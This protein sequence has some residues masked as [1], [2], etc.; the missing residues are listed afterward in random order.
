[1]ATAMHD[2]LDLCRREGIPT[3]LVLMP[4]GPLYRS[5]YTPD[6]HAK[7]QAFL[8]DLQQKHKVPLLDA[9]DWIPE[10]DFNDSHHL[11]LHGAE[12]FS[13]RMVHDFLLPILSRL[14]EP[15]QQARVQ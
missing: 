5:W 8:Q 2:A 4:E 11:L 7:I 1:M 12:T 15:K 10:E 13:D 3:A 14:A 9:R 6:T